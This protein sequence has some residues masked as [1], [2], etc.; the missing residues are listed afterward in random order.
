[1]DPLVKLA[2]D[3]L[4]H[5]DGNPVDLG[6][7]GDRQPVIHPGSD[8]RVVRPRDLARGPGLG[9][10]RCRSFLVADRCRRQDREHAG[11]SRGMLGRGRGVRNRWL[12]GL[13]F[14]E[15]L[16]RLAALAI[17]SRSS[18]RGCCCCSRWL[19][20]GCPDCLAARD[21]EASVEMRALAKLCPALCIRNLHRKLQSNQW[22]GFDPNILNYDTGVRRKVGRDRPPSSFLRRHFYSLL[23]VTILR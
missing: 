4:D 19:S 9:V 11:F 16:G 15:R 13:R 8:A 12:D 23:C 21:I 5:A 17:R 1:L 14:E 10:D 2:D 3:A 6:D 7:L 22:L 20:K 18:P